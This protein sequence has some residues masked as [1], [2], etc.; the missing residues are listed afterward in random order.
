M[1]EA[2][3]YSE[4][5]LAKLNKGC[6]GVMP[7]WAVV[8]D[9]LVVKLKA[10]ETAREY[11]TH[12]VLRRLIMM[13]RCIER[14]YELCPPDTRKLDDPE[15]VLDITMYLQSFYIHLYGVFENLAR[16]SIEM[17]GIDFLD[18]HKRTASF[19]STKGNKKVKDTLPE[20]LKQY[21]LTEGMSQWCKHLNSFRHSLAHRISLY[22]PENVLR[23]ED[24]DSYQKLE[25][26]K[27]ELW[28]DRANCKL[29]LDGD[30]QTWLKEWMNI[31][32]QSIRLN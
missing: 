28:K 25:A 3:F 7:S 17:S 9:Y 19:L 20:E 27:V 12:G 22:I 16:V 5:D 32:R 6:R 14:I 11:I 2:Q 23:P 30:I 4:Q 10:E 26:E 31:A 8:A 21:F 18:Q 29:E 15:V 1:S 24:E 13:R